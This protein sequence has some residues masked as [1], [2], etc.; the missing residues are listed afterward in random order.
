MYKLCR[1]HVFLSFPSSWL[2]APCFM[3]R[4]E[5][6]INLLIV[7]DCLYRNIKLHL[8]W[9]NKKCWC[10]P[11]RLRTWMTSFNMKNIEMTCRVNMF[12]R[13]ESNMKQ[14]S[15]CQSKT[16][17]AG[18]GG[19]VFLVQN[20]CQRAVLTGFKSS[21]YLKKYNFGIQLPLSLMWSH[22]AV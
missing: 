15:A 6:N 19:I 7:C 5:R 14:I 11:I 17:I 10:F 1:L 2:L 4:C 13:S 3:Q 8:E 21:S 22:A 12:W 9:T 20:L 18:E 16:N